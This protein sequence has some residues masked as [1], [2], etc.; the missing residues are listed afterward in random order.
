MTTA[1]REF[2]L[3]RSRD[4]PKAHEILCHAFSFNASPPHRAAV[5]DAFRSARRPRLTA[6]FD[7]WERLNRWL[8]A[9]DRHP[10]PPS[11][12]DPTVVKDQGFK[13]GLVRAARQVACEKVDQGAEGRAS[14]AEQSCIKPC[15]ACGWGPAAGWLALRRLTTNWGGSADLFITPAHQDN[16]LEQ[17]SGRRWLASCSRGFADDGIDISAEEMRR[18][19]CR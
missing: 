5:R 4:S 15:A 13:R 10:A 17:F 14:W 2:S 18:P 3:W 6:S 7:A 9:E 1:L 11:P 8:Q 16:D 12:K 19:H